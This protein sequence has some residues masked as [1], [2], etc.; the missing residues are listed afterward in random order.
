[1]SQVER[2]DAVPQLRRQLAI[3]NERG[4]GRTSNGRIVSLTNGERDRRSISREALQYV[5]ALLRQ[6]T[7]Q[8][9]DQA[10]IL[11]TVSTAS[12]SSIPE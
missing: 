8:L 1:M 11:T 9:S 10:I 12:L 2:T 7:Q 6:S 5:Q 4:I 3:I